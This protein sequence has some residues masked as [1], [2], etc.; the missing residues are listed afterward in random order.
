MWKFAQLALAATVS[1]NFGTLDD[2]IHELKD[3]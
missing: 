2:I 1:A 3:G